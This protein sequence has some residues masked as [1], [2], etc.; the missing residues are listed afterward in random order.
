MTWAEAGA[1][2]A[3]VPLIAAVTGVMIMM[4]DALIRKARPR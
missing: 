1:L 4:L 2:A 3:T